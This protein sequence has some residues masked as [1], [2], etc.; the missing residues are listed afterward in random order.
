MSDRPMTFLERLYLPE[1]LRGLAVTFRHLAR[2]LLDRRRLPTLE[3]PEAKPPIPARWRGRHRL[4]RYPGGELKCTA[5]MLCSTSCPARCIHIEAEE[6][7]GN[8]AEK[9]PARFEIDLLRCVYCGLCVE[10]CPCDS[11]YMDTGLYAL[12]GYDRDDA[13]IDLA[14]LAGPVSDDE[15]ERNL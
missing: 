4:K 14:R 3:Y 11:I 7:P 9:R 15:K 13:L 12:S 6:M 10:A 8:P 5:C 1:I 2:N